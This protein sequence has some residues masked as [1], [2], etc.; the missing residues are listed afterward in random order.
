MTVRS[1]PETLTLAELP[2]ARLTYVL[3]PLKIVYLGVPKN[4]CTSLTWLIAD[5]AGEN[6]DG[7]RA[8]LG[9]EA[10]DELAIHRRALFRHV[11][12]LVD[13]EPGLRR[14]IRPD[15]GWFVFGTVRDPRA[16]LFSAW[17]NKMLLHDPAYGQWRDADWY[18]QPPEH[19]D[20]V[21]RDFARFVELLR[22]EPDHPLA[23]DP[24]F[25]DQIVFLRPDLIPYS[26]IYD[27]AEMPALLADLG[28]H[29]RA[30][31]VD[32]ELTLRR[33]NDTVLRP[34][35]R[36]LNDKVRSHIEE[37]YAVDFDSFGHLW[38]DAKIARAGEWTAESLLEIQARIMLH[39]RIEHLIRTG[40]QHRER[41]NRLAQQA[42]SVER[43]LESAR[44]QT[45]TAQRERDRARRRAAAADERVRQLQA[46][47][48][49][50]LGLAARALRGR[51]RALARRG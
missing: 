17:Q 19:A 23:G 24:H 32:R 10:T 26:R 5:L 49:T 48:S 18:P 13:V 50:R 12:T 39:E 45:R 9:W 30:H 6:L 22:T 36:V 38:D 47:R 8:R 37:I 20:D 29:L 15:N 16:R 42:E 3:E 34:T 11:P 43:E 41:A 31:G 1:L 46:M 4:A 51:L 21:V 7:F 2:W 33:A 14:A 25:R 27:V 35:G 44:K 28:A 40:R